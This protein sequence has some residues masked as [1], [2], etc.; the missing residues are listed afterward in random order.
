MLANSYFLCPVPG[1]VTGKR[2]SGKVTF[3]ETTTV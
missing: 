1:N 3:R 2:L